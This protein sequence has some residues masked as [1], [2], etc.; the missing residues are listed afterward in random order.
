MAAVVHYGIAHSQLFKQVRMTL[1]EASLNP[2]REVLLGAVKA[3]RLKS[4]S[5]T[6]HILCRLRGPS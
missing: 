6:V 4:A 3:Y 5:E 1:H 2:L